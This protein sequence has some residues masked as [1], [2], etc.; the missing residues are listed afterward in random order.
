MKLLYLQV[1]LE[2]FLVRSLFNGFK[3]VIANK[4]LAHN[5][6]IEKD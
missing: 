1:N 5:R 2:K 3:D 6:S 4:Y